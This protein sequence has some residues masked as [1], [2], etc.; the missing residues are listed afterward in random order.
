MVMVAAEALAQVHGRG[1]CGGSHLIRD[2]RGLSG[3][4][5][6]SDEGKDNQPAG[7]GEDATDGEGLDGWVHGFG[8]CD[9]TV[10]AT[11]RESRDVRGLRRGRW[12]RIHQR[13]EILPS[14]GSASWRLTGCCRASSL[15]T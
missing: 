7:P 13:M 6:C 1:T 9:F 3:H 8:S 11:Q 5:E 10:A 12:R 4:D 14:V 15:A 2:T